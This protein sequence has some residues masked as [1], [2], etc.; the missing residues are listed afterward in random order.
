MGLLE[1]QEPGSPVLLC[2]AALESDQ[3]GGD[4]PSLYA[5]DRREPTSA[6]GPLEAALEQRF[7][8]DLFLLLLL[9]QAVDGPQDP[10]LRGAA[11]GLA[12]EGGV[13]GAVGHRAAGARL[14]RL[15]G[16]RP[17]RGLATPRP[18]LVELDGAVLGEQAFDL[19]EAT[20][21]R[22]RSIFFAAMN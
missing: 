19:P 2:V 14:A 9:E 7:E 21:M 15:L 1:G 10:G 16:R 5:A 20:T 17:L 18:A 11:H 6:G 22:R 4:P 3:P 13:D 8:V 12:H